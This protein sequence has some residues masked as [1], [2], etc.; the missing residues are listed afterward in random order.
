MVAVV[1]GATA[2][3]GLLSAPVMAAI[4]RLNSIPLGRGSATISWTGS[5]GLQPTIGPIS[6]SARGLSIA[7][8]GVVPT[9]SSLGN[10]AQGSTSLSIPSSV[11]VAD[12]NGTLAGTPFTLDI[13]LNLSHLNLTSKGV[14]AFGTVTGSFHGQTVHATLT[15]RASSS[16]AQ[17]HGTIGAD[18]V[19][20]T[21]KKIVHQGMRTTA[22][23]TFNVT[24]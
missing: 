18:H 13:A 22:F 24:K 9:T 6:G 21:I 16:T 5:T 17:F 4:A 3:L 11:P 23:A 15:S 19:E 20:G 14:Q 12:I 7:A 10:S 1:V 8:T 2:A